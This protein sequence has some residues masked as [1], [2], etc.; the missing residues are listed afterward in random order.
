MLA[1]YL[2]EKNNQ[3]IVVNDKFIYCDS[4]YMIWK[5][6][7]SLIEEKYYSSDKPISLKKK[8]LKKKKGEYILFRFFELKYAP[9]NYLINNGFKIVEV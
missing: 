9:E 1:P 8:D 5:N 6:G 7:A 3:R 4:I 2:Y